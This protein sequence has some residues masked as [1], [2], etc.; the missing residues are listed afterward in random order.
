MEHVRALEEMLA[1]ILEGPKKP[2]ADLLFAC[3]A[4]LAQVTYLFRVRLFCRGR[5]HIP[6]D[7]SLR[8]IIQLVFE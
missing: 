2:C 1:E 3:V 8:E 7:K 6:P 5:V 4:N